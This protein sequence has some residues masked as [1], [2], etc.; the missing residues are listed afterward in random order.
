MN[1]FAVL[2]FPKHSKIKAMHGVPELRNYLTRVRVGIGNGKDVHYALVIGRHNGMQTSRTP[3]VEELQKFVPTSYLY[4]ADSC[5]TI[6][7]HAF[8]DVECHKPLGPSFDSERAAY[9]KAA[10]DL[11]LHLPPIYTGDLIYSVM[12]RSM[13]SRT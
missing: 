5:V 9:C 12:V 6:A 7:G 3:T 4:Y 2:F 8:N 11:M 1:L 13:P 10:L